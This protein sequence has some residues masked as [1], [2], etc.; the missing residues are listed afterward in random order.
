[1]AKPIFVMRLR[2]SMTHEEE[3]N[4]SEAIYKSD[5]NNEYHLILIRND[6]DKDEFEVYNAEKMT[7][8]DFN[9]IVN[10]FK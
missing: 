5:M 3:R 4:V 7:R 1:M 9:N 10:K 6:K 8:Q 2:D